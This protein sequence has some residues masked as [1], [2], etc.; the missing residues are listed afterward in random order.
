MSKTNPAASTG[1]FS[2][3]TATDQIYRNARDGSEDH[4]VRGREYLERIWQAGAQYVDR[5]AADKATRDLASVFWELQLAYAL[6]SAGKRLAPRP[7]LAYKN[8]KGPDLFA[9]GAPGVWIEAVVV[10]SG[11][12][13]DA[14]QYPELMKAYS[15]NPDGV[16]LRLRSV[17]RDKSAKIQSYIADGT[18]KPGQPT[19]IA[20][21]GVILPHRFSG[22]TPPEMVQG[23]LPCQ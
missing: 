5:D 23:R 2:S 3:A 8:N 4:H 22:I 17:I 20:I 9:A 10:R 18:I 13:P 15:Y 1:F 21:S 19:I 16:I 6:T 14:L 11:D 7:Q 12:G